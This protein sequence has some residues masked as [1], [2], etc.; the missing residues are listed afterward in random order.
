M[1]EDKPQI[2]LSVAAC[3]CR[4]HGEP[5]RK[6][7]PSGYLMF[8]LHAVTTAIEHNEEVAEYAGRDAHK[9]NGVLAEW[10]PLC[11]LLTVEQRREGYRQACES[12]EFGVKNLCA[13]CRKWA[14]GQDCTWQMPEVG[15]RQV[16]ICFDCL[17]AQ[18]CKT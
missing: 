7:W 11:R 4:V 12:K 13:A 17:A 14:V 6:N 8:S 9:L 5:F 16:H 2:D 1:S 3:V 10:G 18:E 15:V